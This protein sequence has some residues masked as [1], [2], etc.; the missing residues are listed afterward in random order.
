MKK[1]SFFIIVIAFVSINILFYSRVKQSNITLDN[2]LHIST[3]QAELPGIFNKCGGT[4]IT[5]KHTTFKCLSGKVIMTAW[6]TYICIDGNNDHC[7][8]GQVGFREWCN[9]PTDDWNT[10]K[11]ILCNN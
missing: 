6:T 9:Q 4:D 5:H 10:V 1:V 7:S 3:A 11:F 8:K 2:F